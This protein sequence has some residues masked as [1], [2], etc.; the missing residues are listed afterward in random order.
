MPGWISSFYT[1]EEE[2][3]ARVLAVTNRVQWEEL[4]RTHAVC[5]HCS[6]KGHIN[7]KCHKYLAAIEAGKIIRANLIDSKRKKNPPRTLAG[8]SRGVGQSKMKDPK[9]KAFLSAFQ[10]LFTNEDY[11]D[12]KEDNGGN[13]VND[14]EEDGN[15]DNNDDDLHGIL[16]MI[17]LLEE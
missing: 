8:P 11:D 2:K 6:E 5:H 13:N 10:A 15:D 3:E 17:G 16:L 1:T 9:V 14:K 4:V 12:N 7:P